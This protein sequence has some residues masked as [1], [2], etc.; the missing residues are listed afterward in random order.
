MHLSCSRKQILF[1]SNKP[2]HAEIVAHADSTQRL[3]I[4]RTLVASMTLEPVTLAPGKRCDWLRPNQVQEP[5][6]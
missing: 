5:G 3:G 2:T 4:Y 1:A 6:N